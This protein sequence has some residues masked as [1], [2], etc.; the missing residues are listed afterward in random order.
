MNVDID[1]RRVHAGTG[2]VDPAGEAVVLVHGAGMDHTAWQQQT[3]W[4]AHRALAAVAVDLPGHGP[5]EGP[6]LP[7]IAAMADW[8]GEFVTVAG[9]SPA[10]LV[11][12]SMGSLAALELAARQ[13]ALLCSLV[14]LGTAASMPVHPDLR[15]AARAGDELAVDLIC[16]WGHGVAAHAGGHP[17]PGMWMIGSGRALLTRTLG[18]VLASDLQACADY[19]GAPA[20]A[21]QV[22]CPVTIVVG[23]A[24]RMTPPVAARALADMCGA[25]VVELPDAGHMMMIEAPEAVRQALLAAIR[26]GR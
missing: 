17:A 26:R 10:H 15:A 12:H 20:A 4:L 6:P 13:P 9:L 7:T 2:A 24:D 21:A 3:R 14:L 23:T 16:A 8:L 22:S 19:E 1:G 18:E 11:G 5:S 25:E